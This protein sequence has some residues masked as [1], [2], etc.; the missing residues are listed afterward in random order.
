MPTE[1]LVQFVG[2]SKLWSNADR[3]IVLVRGDCFA[4]LPRLAG[5]KID[6]VAT[7]PPYGCTDNPW[8]RAPQLDRWW[9]LVLPTVKSAAVFA[10]FCQQPFTTALICSNRKRWRYEL[11]W[12]KP[13][14]TG[15]LNS[16]SKP[17][18]CHEH[19]QLFCDRPSQATYNPQMTE[20]KPYKCKRRNA[21]TN[22]GRMKPGYVSESKGGRYPRSVLEFANPLHRAG[23]PTQKPLAL[24]EWI[25]RTFSNPGDLVLDPYMGS[26]TT[27]EACLRT[28]RRF[29]GIEQE[30]R[31]F[32]MARERLKSIT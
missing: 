27:A 3:S 22:Y 11:V 10:M 14:A 16:R 25:I 24:V 8:D 1:N 30:E 17:L 6:C 28:G 5:A 2:K 32:D 18:R 29:I 4:L 15:F 12:H 26:G 19:I 9:E 21:S 20:G 7:D 23:H 13:R 31:Y